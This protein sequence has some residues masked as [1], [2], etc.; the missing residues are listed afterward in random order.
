MPCER[1]REALIEAAVVGEALSADLRAHV[2]ACSS[3]RAAFAEEQQLSAAIDSGL[4]GMS[5]NVM[6]ASLVPGVRTRLNEQKVSGISWIRIGEAFAAAALV[7]LVAMF[8]R[9]SHREGR[10][11][12]LVVSTVAPNPVAKEIPNQ[13]AP[14]VEPGKYAV[15]VA[16]A[17][18]KRQPAVPSRAVRAEVPVLVPAGQKE[19]VDTLLA[20]LSAGNMKPQSLIADKTAEPEAISELSPLGIPE[21]Q[22]KPLAA[23]SE[24]SGPTK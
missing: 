13:V 15:G 18:P 22:I 2:D 4:H 24:E 11:Q 9:G 16:G 6:P 12:N 3:C 7:V 20:A 8:I 5:N 14:V 10:E 19:A 23:V 17:K 21:I 1:Y